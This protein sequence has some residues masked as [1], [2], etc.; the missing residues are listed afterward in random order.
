MFILS[1]Q[2]VT[3]LLI[4]VLVGYL[5]ARLG[6]LTEERTSAL[7]HYLTQIALPCMLLAIGFTSYSPEKASTILYG[8][9]ATSFAETFCA[10]LA[11]L[12]ISKKNNPDVHIERGACYTLNAGFVGG[13][14][15]SSMMGS[16]AFFYSAGSQIA[17][18]VFSWVIMFWMISGEISFAGFKKAW[19]S[20]T[21]VSL[22][23]GLVLFFLP[24]TLPAPV[25]S[26]IDTIGSTSGPIALIISGTGLFGLDLKK[27]LKKK[28]A[29]IGFVIKLLVC[30][31]VLIPFYKLFPTMPEEMLAT[32]ICCSTSCPAILPV[33]AL[34]YEQDHKYASA[35]LAIGLVLC[36]LTLP[37]TVAIYEA[38]I[39]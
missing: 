29:Y 11:I 10:I 26:A 27:V 9:L 34:T 6:I 13:A 20:K 22:A 33:F 7:T 25:T 21:M 32:L 23:I 4:M 36:M 15:I 18:N 31:L 28:N 8:F 35:L 5:G 39:L 30:P 19:L 2:T 24:I 3:K 37:L 14:I 16:G 17:A 38:V 12:L 1:I